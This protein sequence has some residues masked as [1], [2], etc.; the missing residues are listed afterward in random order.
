MNVFTLVKRSLWYYRRR[1]VGVLLAVMVSGAILVGALLV[2]DCVRYSLE[3]IVDLRLGAVEFAMTSRD[4]FFRDELGGELDVM[5]APVIELSG[6]VANSDGTKRVNRVNVFGVD[7]RFF[8]I[9]G[10]KNLFAGDADGL[11]LNEPLAE[12]LGV[13][14]GDEVVLRIGRVGGMSRDIPLM[15]EG[16]M[17]AVHRGE[18]TAVAGEDDF[19]RFSLQANQV[20][21]LNVFV[22]LGWLQEKIEREGLVNTLLVGGEV[23]DEVLRKHLRLADFGL[24]VREV[25]AGGE[26]EV[27][28]RRVFI[29]DLITEAL[30]A[31]S[32]EGRGYLTYFVN[33]LRAGEKATPYS[34]VT[35]IDSGMKDDEIVINEWLAEDIGVKVG[36]RITLRY[37]VMGAR[38][39]LVEESSE[40]TVREVVSM[41]SGALDGSFMPDFPGL[42]DAENCSDWDPGIPIDLDKIRDKDEV[43]WD[44][45]GGRPKAFVS[46]GAGRRMWAN[47]FGDSTGVRYPADT[48]GREEIES[49][50]VANLDGR[51]V[52]LFFRAVRQAGVKAGGEAT[53]FGQ[54]F[55]GLSMFLIASA[56]ILTGLVFAFG[57]ENRSGEAGMLLA[58]GF[59]KKLVR[60]V[61]LLEGAV[62]SVVGSVFGAAA[63]VVYTKG[64]IFGLGTVWKGA[65]AGTAIEFHG[66]LSTV[67]VGVG[68]GVVVSFFA[69][70]VT[71]G[72]QMKKP[73]KLLLAGGGEEFSRTGAKVKGKFSFVIAFVCVVGAVF[74]LARSGGG[75]SAAVAGAFFGAGSLLLI[76]GLCV[77][78]AFLRGV[79][80]NVAGAVHSVG[81]LSRRNCRRRS[82]RSVAVVALIAAGSFLVVSIGA[83]KHDP[84]AHAEERDSGTGGFALFGESSIP[85]VVDLNSES[86]R[87][88]FGL[89]DGDVQVVQ[90]RVRDGDDA[91]C[92]N[93]NRAQRPRVLGV[94]A[95][96]FGRRGAFGE[97][98]LMAG[99]EADGWDVLNADFGESVIPAVADNTTVVWALGKK[100]GDDVEYV[101]DEGRR[102][103]IR[104]AGVSQNSILQGNLIISE[105]QF[106]SRF[107]S[108]AGYRMF[109]V[110]TARGKGGEVADALS[111]SLRDHG[112]DIVGAGERLAQFSEVENT[113]LSIFQLLGGLALLLGSVALGLVVL[114]NVLERR[115][116][117]AML[118]AVGFSRNLLT[119]MVIYEHAGLLL[120]GLVCGV[121]AALIAII[122]ALRGP[123][124][125]I[126]H[127]FLAIT[128]ASIAFSGLM[129]IW[130]SAWVALRGALLEALRNE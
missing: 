115:G 85:V 46:L 52:G 89:A 67:C 45:W 1:N 26:L 124:A 43:Y 16:D 91:S 12:R 72:R 104:L 60:R 17:T 73:A 84:L 48:V 58:V 10:G 8:S 35:A 11:V 128:V 25:G 13:G 28:S 53:D 81:G 88:K 9:G 54:L 74:V 18:V 37:F 64:M 66:S 34:M 102:F 116:E 62:L 51:R 86:M 31:V 70:F 78:Y 92:L 120:V 90:M 121:V 77:V 80:A 50:L 93:L 23:S 61:F 106:V 110:D 56:V 57:V 125:D 29:D 71:L 3:R 19:G 105:K 20:A 32:N 100:L 122:P 42:S 118:R 109:L 6:L 27:R 95:E 55:L 39:E 96:E 82:G 24:E 65:V 33:E 94:D 30:E 68:A 38:R 97:I 21:P 4:R 83:F 112:M 108:E 44:D 40:F 7:V 111:G 41:E 103:T 63:G 15:P 79:G 36:E 14:V 98:T 75:E 114:I 99:T 101:D 59:P 47:R 2:G 127:A 22:P 107:P 49:G 130:V 119:K 126:G 117:L 123:G 76:G 87:K 69:I 113:Y 129:W 5:A